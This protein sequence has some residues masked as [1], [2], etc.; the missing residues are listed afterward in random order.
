[1]IFAMVSQMDRDA[2]YF[3]YVTSVSRIS[4]IFILY[5]FDVF[6]QIFFYPGIYFLNNGCHFR[7]VP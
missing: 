2:A 7:L 4:L 3:S 5:S 6:Y 1:M